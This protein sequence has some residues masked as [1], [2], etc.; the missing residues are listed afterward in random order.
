MKKFIIALLCLTTMFTLIGCSTGKKESTD[1]SD[2]SDIAPHTETNK[3]ESFGN[4][5]NDTGYNMMASMEYLTFE[6]ACELVTDAVVAT[7]EGSRPYGASFTEYEFT[8]K[9]RLLGNAPESICV[10]AMDINVYVGHESL[11]GYNEQ[12]LYLE[13]GKDYLLLLEHWTSV[14]NKVDKY[15]FICNIVIDTDTISNS[16]MYNQPIISHSSGFDF[17]H[18]DLQ[19]TTAYISELI[20]NNKPSAQPAKINNLNDLVSLSTDIVVVTVDKLEQTV[21]NDFRDTEFYSCTVNETLKGNIQVDSQIEIIFFS[22][23]VQPGDEII[24][25]LNNY[26]NAT[27]YRLTSKESVMPTNKKSEILSIITQ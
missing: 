7:F 3:T 6:D 13:H 8:V 10:Y 4:S 21:K 5:G 14:Y 12:E 1:S 19:S 25:A 26:D 17:A 2:E 11:S 24:V 18:S 27:Y 9:N 15:H 16:T 22:G 23:S 20:K